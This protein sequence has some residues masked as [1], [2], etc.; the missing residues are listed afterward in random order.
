MPSF[1]RTKDNFKFYD[2]PA[3]DATGSFEHI[4]KRPRIEE[5]AQDPGIQS[6]LVNHVSGAH[7]IQ[8]TVQSMDT[9]VSELADS[10]DAVGEK[11]KNC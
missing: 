3:S 4:Y 7:D 8:K 9:S 5:Q 2:H 1:Y 6:V 11:L 10:I